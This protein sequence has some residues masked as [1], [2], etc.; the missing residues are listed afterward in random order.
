MTS[1]RFF[2]GEEQGSGGNGKEC[3]EEAT[4][5]SGEEGPQAIGQ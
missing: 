5:R 1:Q 4:R 2:Y 3:D